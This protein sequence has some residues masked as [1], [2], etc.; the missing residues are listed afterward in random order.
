MW[1]RITMSTN[2]PT[3]PAPLFDLTNRVALINGASRGIGATIATAYASTGALVVLASCKQDGVDAVATQIQAS[4]GRSLAVAAH[5]GD[6]TA[7]EAL[8]DRAVA[9]FGGID[10]LVNNAATNPHFGPL[11]TADEGQWA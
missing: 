4:C 7:V 2:Q 8:I 6:K 9:E 11:L 3:T 10:I 5:T 1:V